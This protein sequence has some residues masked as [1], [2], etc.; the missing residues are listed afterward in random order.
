L[1]KNHLYCGECSQ[2]MKRLDDNS[3]DLTVTSPPY[4]DLRDYNGYVFDFESIASELFRVT[5]CG[6]VV[7]WIV[8]DKTSNGSESGESFRQ[9]LHFKEI[10]FNLHDTM[11][12]EKVALRFPERYRYFQSFEYM[13][14]L[15]KGTPKTF[16][17]I[18]EPTA[19][20]RKTNYVSS[21]LKDG[22]LKTSTCERKSQI[23]PLRNVWR[24]SAAYMSG[25]KDKFA[26]QHPALFPEK[27][28]QDHILSWSN[29][30][31]TVLDPMCGSGTTLK[32]AL[33]NDRKFIGIEISR[34]YCEI[35][36]RRIR[37]FKEKRYED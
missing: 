11:I 17:P 30:G 31:D 2:I 10:G 5:K 21:R 15:S 18:K 16:N 14:V 20:Q 26:Y 27:L 7:V 19:D 9:A 28:A 1:S 8:A 32:M 29:P 6:G 37:E 13:F 3:I 23:R 35:A 33:K 25:T 24:I 34:E 12:Y 4:G 22:T 36:L